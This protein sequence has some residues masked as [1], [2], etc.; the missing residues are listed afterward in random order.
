MTQKLDRKFRLTHRILPLA[1]FAAAAL[2]CE[3]TDVDLTL[4]DRYFDFAKGVWPQ[5]DAWWAEKLIH[6]RGRDLITCIGAGALL[7]WLASFISDRLRPQ[8]WRFTY[9]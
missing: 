2:W 3:L 9:R 6:L 5:K 7:G 1:V 8:R 4:S